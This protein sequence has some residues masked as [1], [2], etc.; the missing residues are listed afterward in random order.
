MTNNRSEI[1]WEGCLGKAGEEKSQKVTWKCLRVID[2]FTFLTVVTNSQIFH[3][4]LSNCTAQIYSLLYVHH[5]SIKLLKISINL[6]SF[7]MLIQIKG[8][9]LAQCF[10]FCL[11]TEFPSVTVFQSHDQ[12]KVRIL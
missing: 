5:A 7:H 9:F 8:K 11:L 12:V 2:M 1:F 10:K 4:N 3:M 6:Y